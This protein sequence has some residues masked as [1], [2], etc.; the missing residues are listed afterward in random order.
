[1]GADACGVDD[2]GDLGDACCNF[3]ENGVTYELDYI[4]SDSMNN[5][6]IIFDQRVNAG[7]EFGSFSSITFTYDAEPI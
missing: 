3:D 4:F 7:T 1:M 5:Y 2:I 6:G